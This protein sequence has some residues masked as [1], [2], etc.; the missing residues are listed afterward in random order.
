MDSIT[1]TVQKLNMEILQRV[2]PPVQTILRSST[3]R[4]LLAA[5][6]AFNLLKT[7][8]R[9][10]SAYVLNNWTADKYD[11]SREIVF[12]TGGSSGIG[13]GVARDLAS[14]GIKV[15]VADIQEPT[16]PLRMS[17]HFSS[18][19]SYDEFI[20]SRGGYRLTVI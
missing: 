18:F 2:P 10:L 4:N 8:N 1:A 14:R 9:V 11:W 6:I 13:Q 5:V 17:S 20:L 7:L 3:T 15:I 16:A 19:L 12:L